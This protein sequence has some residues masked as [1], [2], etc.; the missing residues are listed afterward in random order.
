MEIPSPIPMS[1]PT[2]ASYEAALCGL[3]FIEPRTPSQRRFGEN[4]DALWSEFRGDLTDG[5]QERA[6]C[7]RGRHGRLV[8]RLREEAEQ[9]V[10]EVCAGAR[11]VGV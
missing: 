9:E 11:T 4:A 2:R 7:I 6:G 1:D 3:R 5:D 8:S 10:E